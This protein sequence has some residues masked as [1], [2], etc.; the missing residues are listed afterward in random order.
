MPLEPADML[1]DLAQQ[2]PASYFPR[3]ETPV[4]FNFDQGLAAEE[5]FP[6]ADLQRV[7]TTVLDRDRG[8]AL[9]YVSLGYDAERD[10]ILYPPTQGELALGYPGLRAEV[11][12]WIGRTQGVA[13]LDADHVILTSGSVQAI[14]LA[15][16]ALLN[17]GEGA[18]VEKAT[19]PYA[20][21]FMQM[22]GADVRAVEIDEHGLVP[23]SL[24]QRLG[25]L[26]RD[27]V[28]PKLLYVIPTFQ[29]PTCVVMPEDRRRRLLEIAEE[30]N[31][32]VLEDS[33]YADLRYGGE[34]VPSLLSLDTGGRV[35]QS[36]GFSKNLAPGLRLGWISAAPALV[37]GLAAVRQDLGVSQW[38][39][40]AMELFLVEGLLDPHIAAA[41]QVYRRKRDVAVTA[42]R[43]HCGD[44]VTFDVP[45]GGFYLWLRMGDDVDWVKAQH[46]AAERG[47]FCRPG[48]RF[49]G[50]RDG[51]AFLRLAYSHA[52][53]DEIERGIAVLGEAI[54]SNVR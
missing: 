31:L 50:E 16:S 20:M 10:K 33:I 54:T 15:V 29:L 1:S 34:P 42:V 17:P 24:V 28:R 22:R 2:G 49:L 3:P 25:E 36:H 53:D 39:S 19:F 7:M 35:L 11:A 38:T 18:L 23:D 6:I 13:G 41:N 9:E 21:R 48:E 30:W 40:R 51:Q 26:E 52:A 4:T 45:D 44:L 37:R 8:R 27:G 12:R 43:R 5:T 47:V 46:E 32:V 14:A